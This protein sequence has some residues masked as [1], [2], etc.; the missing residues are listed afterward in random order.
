[1]SL[2]FAGSGT[3]RVGVISS[4]FSSGGR[5]SVLNA[6]IQLATPSFVNVH[7]DAVIRYIGGKII[8]INRLNRD[9]IQILNPELG[10]LTE[11]EFSTGKGT[12]PQDIAFV[13]KS[14]AY[15]SL[16]NS[17]NLLIIN[18]ET[19]LKT[20]QL[21]L[22]NYA[23]TSSTGG[24]GT[25]GFPEM[26]Q[27][28]LEENKLFLQLQRLDRNDLS[29]FPAPNTNSLLLEIDTNTDTVVATYSTPVANPITQIQKITY[30][31]ESFLAMGLSGRLGFLS[32]LDGGIY[33]FQLNT[34]QFLQSPIL[35]E[36]NLG[37]DILNFVIKSE[38]EGFVFS[39]DRNFNKTIWKWNPLTNEKTNI[40]EYYPSSFGNLG[41]LALSRSGKLYVGAANFERPGVNIYD[42]N[43]AQPLKLNS[44]PIDVGLRPFDLVVIE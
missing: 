9:N 43:P 26:H 1:L 13:S 35:S 22:G 25:D 10:F 5:F 30:R 28:F 34:R 8:I 23:E 36:S 37:G 14:K 27:M 39:L 19:G 4:D 3:E 44:L 20:G 17:R 12:N 2:L 11:R 21:D 32:Q 41:G 6:D 33:L 42:T 18:P 15:I 40:V 29:G 24:S 38:T 31:G 16:Y 7:S